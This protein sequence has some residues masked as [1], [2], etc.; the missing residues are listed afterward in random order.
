[1]LLEESL[2]Q[3]NTTLDAEEDSTNSST[4]INRPA[5]KRSRSNNELTD[6]EKEIM[7]ELK[8]PRL[9]ESKCT[10]FTFFEEYVADMTENEKLK[11]HMDILKSISEIKASRPQAVPMYVYTHKN[12]IA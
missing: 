9:Q 4:S 3:N 1:M 8:R 6:I 10:F 5:K 11:L 12:Q 2:E 7:I